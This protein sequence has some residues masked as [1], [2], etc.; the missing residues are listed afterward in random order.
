[1]RT[2]GAAKSITDVMRG[3]MNMLLLRM[4]G[5]EF[6]IFHGDTLTDEWDL[7]R[8]TSPSINLM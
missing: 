3:R 1:M 5:S 6:E 8:E 7:M 2:D 4:K